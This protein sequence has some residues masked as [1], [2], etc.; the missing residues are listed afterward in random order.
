MGNCCK[1]EATSRLDIF[2][3]L[4]RSALNCKK[5]GNVIDTDKVI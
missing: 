5:S 1:I 2:N 3:Q 4:E